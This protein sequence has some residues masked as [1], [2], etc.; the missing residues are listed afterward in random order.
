MEKV[1]I[2]LDDEIERIQSSDEYIYIKLGIKEID[3]S[4]IVALSRELNQ[5]KLESLRERVQEHGWR[6]VSPR[7]L[8]LILMPNGKYA[9]DG[10]GNHRAFLSNELG[11]KQIK[12]DIGTF[13]KKDHLTAEQLAYIEARERERSTIFKEIRREK[14]EEKKSEL[15]YKVEDIN[16]ELDDFLLEIY[17]KVNP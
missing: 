12:A 6:D 3:P 14:D 16:K 5:D 2:D 15:S 17:Y 11:I 1:W 10:G 4:L 8:D 13:M 7:D 9:V